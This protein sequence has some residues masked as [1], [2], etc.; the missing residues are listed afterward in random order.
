MFT[1]RAVCGRRAAV[2]LGGFL[3]RLGRRAS[4]SVGRQVLAGV[5]LQIIGRGVS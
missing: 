1:R 3:R 5:R 4:V 2:T